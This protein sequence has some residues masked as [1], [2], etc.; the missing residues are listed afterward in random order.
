M[1]RFITFDESIEDIYKKFLIK[2]KKLVKKY[3][4]ERHY[5][6]FYHMHPN[7]RLKKFFLIYPYKLLKT[8]IEAYMP[9]FTISVNKI[10]KNNKN[11]FICIYNNFYEGGVKE[12][13]LKF[14]TKEDNISIK[15]NIKQLQK[16]IKIIEY[17]FDELTKS[18]IG[19]VNFYK[20]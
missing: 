6:K 20:Q 1:P 16:V 14:S 2:N 8:G 7:R 3:L 19:T 11:N 10:D 15:H 12:I 5:K 17:A 4:K 18:F 9:L 13:K